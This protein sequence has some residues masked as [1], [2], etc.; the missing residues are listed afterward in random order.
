MQIVF[1]EVLLIRQASDFASLLFV[2]TD[3]L[4]HIIFIK[5]TIIDHMRIDDVQLTILYQDIV[6][7]EVLPRRE[8]LRV[9]ANLIRLILH[10]VIAAR[11]LLQALVLIQKLG[12]R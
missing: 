6:L 11:R 5:E 2:A 4:H 12:R 3:V 8:L 10:I 7:L 1:E 9:A